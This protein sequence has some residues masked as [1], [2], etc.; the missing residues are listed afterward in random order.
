MCA[1]KAFTSQIQVQTAFHCNS[2]D[3]RLFTERNP[4][5]NL[6][7]CN[8]AHKVDVGGKRIKRTAKDEHGVLQL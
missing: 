7:T 6:H 8:I 3:F 1:W 4:S 2:I 5:E